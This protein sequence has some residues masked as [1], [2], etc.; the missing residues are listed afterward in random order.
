MEVI[1][2]SSQKSAILSVSCKKGKVYM[3]RKATLD[4]IAKLAGVSKSAVSMIL[5]EKK[6]VTF[7][8]ETVKKVQDAAKILGY[9]KKD[10]SKNVVHL[11]NKDTILV[12]CPSVS[13]P[14]FATLAQA[15]EQE[16]NNYGLHVIIQNTFRDKGRELEYLNQ[17]KGSN[18]F[19]IICTMT[20]YNTVLL[21]EIN[22]TIPV[23]IVN[24]KVHDMELDTVEVNNYAAGVLLAEHL[25]EL[26]H[27]NIAY[28]S[29][30]IDPIYTSRVRRLQ[31]VLETYKKLCPKGRVLVKSKN[32]TPA[33]EMSNVDF[34]REVGYDLTMELLKHKDITAIVAINDMVAYGV[35]DALQEKNQRIPEDYSICGFDNLFPS[36]FRNISL[37][38]IEHFIINKGQFAVEM[39]RKRRNTPSYPFTSTK[40]LFKHELVVRNST[41][42]P[43]EIEKKK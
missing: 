39:I 27:K 30:T 31:G 14:Y 25:I 38:T 20:P 22:E 24:D 42:I 10:P 5:N 40:I 2:Q 34:E 23:V 36:K 16:A 29:T 15:I 18:L 4:D 17:V 3:K 43:R 21:E 28:V 9:N 8:E 26:G 13:N 32:I 7:L 19:G 11:F 37:T 12:F 33:A 41:G 6:G 35:M 1:F